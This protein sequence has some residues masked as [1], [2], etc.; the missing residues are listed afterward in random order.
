TGDETR[1]RVTQWETV[2][3]VQEVQQRGA[4]EMVLNMMNQDGVRKG[5]DLTQL[6]KVRDVSRVLLIASGGAGSMKHFLEA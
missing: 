6:N 4:G 3:W 5:Y 1:T 2:E